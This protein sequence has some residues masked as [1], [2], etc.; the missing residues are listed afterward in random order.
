MS[1]T[2]NRILNSTSSKVQCKGFTSKSSVSLI[3]LGQT[4][5]F[6][7]YSVQTNYLSAHYVSQFLPSPNHY[8]HPPLPS[9]P[10]SICNITVRSRSQNPN[11]L[12]QI[13][14]LSSLS[15]LPA[16]V[17]IRTGPIAPT[18][19]SARNPRTNPRSHNQTLA[20]TVFRYYQNIV[21]PA[22]VSTPFP[23]LH[24]GI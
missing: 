23:P 17:S 15:S 7:V 8:H 14:N 19:H 11:T 16:P 10:G 2:S 22:E 21:K 13:P 12:P 4:F 18:P 3:E 24:A 1:C 5:F 9:P 6:H 20:V